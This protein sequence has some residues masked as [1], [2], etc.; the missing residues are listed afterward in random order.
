MKFEQHRLEE[1]ERKNRT[2]EPEVRIFLRSAH[3]EGRIMLTLI[4]FV[5][6]YVYRSMSRSKQ[7][8]R[9]RDRSRIF[10]QR[11]ANS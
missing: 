10:L 2:E 1:V 5:Y 6:F 11:F 8:G 3:H 9:Q 7:R 4:H